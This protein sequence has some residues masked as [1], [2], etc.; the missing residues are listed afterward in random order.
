MHWRHRG[1]ASDGAEG[2]LDP[3]VSVQVAIALAYRKRAG[4]NEE[5]KGAS[6]RDEVNMR[7]FLALVGCVIE[8][9][10][11]VCRVDPCDGLSRLLSNTFNEG[12]VA[13][14]AVLEVWNMGSVECPQFIGS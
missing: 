9:D 1:E 4:E 13:V 5:L 6:L 14:K 3:R 12:L 8:E 7:S 11:G 2:V 10:P